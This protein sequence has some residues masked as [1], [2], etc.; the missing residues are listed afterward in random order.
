MSYRNY[1]QPTKPSSNKAFTII[2]LLV[3]IA[4]ISIIASILFPVFAKAREKAR[5]ITCAGNLRQLGMAFQQYTLDNDELLPSTYCCGDGV[6]NKIG[7]WVAFNTFPVND[8]GGR[9]DVKLGNLFPYVKN[10]Q[11]YICPDDAEG[12]VSG[13]S[14]AINSCTMQPMNAAHLYPGKSLAQ[15]DNTSGMML[16]G[17]EAS[18]EFG[19]GTDDGYFRFQNNIADTRHTGGSNLSFVDGHVKWY[20]D[21]QLATQQLQAQTPTG[22]DCPD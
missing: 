2:E 6:N 17:E 5:Q 22:A 16:L 12:Q 10:T 9:F 7:G 21:D 18:H 20:S 4:I 19:R 8:P 3:V 11:V 1:S 15:I 13:D 14:Y